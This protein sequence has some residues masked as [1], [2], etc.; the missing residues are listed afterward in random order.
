MFA[1]LSSFY[2]PMDLL[3]F[4]GQV[5]PCNS[6]FSTGQD[7][8]GVCVCVCIC[9]CVYVCVCCVCV[10]DAAAENCGNHFTSLLGGGVVWP[11]STLLARPDRTGVCVC[12]CVCVRVRVC[13]CVRVRV[14]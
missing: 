7:R 1:E 8:T 14:Y 3:P 6:S 11:F 10:C 2:Q 4:L 12:V 9:V 5:W 13:V